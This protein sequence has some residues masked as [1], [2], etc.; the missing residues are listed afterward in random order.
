MIL[1]QL[2]LKSLR[3]RKFTTLLT[4]LSIALSTTLLL[5]VE[6]TKRAAE[7]GFTQAI[8]QTDLLVGGRTGPLNLILYTVFN[9]GSA[10]NNISWKTY[11][12][13]KKNPAIEWTIPYSLGDGHRG[14]RVVAT[15]ENFYSHYHFRGSGKV[16]LAQGQ[17]ALGIWDATLGAEVAEKLGYKLGDKIVLA[18][19]VTH[20]QGIQMHTDK[21]F[22]V[23][24]VLKKTGTALDQSIYISLYGMEAIHMDWKSN[25]VVFLTD[26]VAHPNAS[27][28]KRYQ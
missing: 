1:L 12:D 13:I 20:G 15:D 9:M 17:P 26:K 2:A 11:E 24:G 14:F 27:T 25:H 28:S 21:P 3:N 6:R 16:E 8:S 19:G 22:T 7:E 5:S 10:S 18:H 4:V 23:V